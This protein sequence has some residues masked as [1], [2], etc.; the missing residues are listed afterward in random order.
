MPQNPIFQKNVEGNVDTCTGKFRDMRPEQILGDISIGVDTKLHAM[1][2]RGR[3]NWS[4]SSGG[5][6]SALMPTYKELVMKGEA[7]G[8]DPRGDL[9]RR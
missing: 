3:G 2:H 1:G 6:A 5:C 4:G 9:R 7:S 8:A